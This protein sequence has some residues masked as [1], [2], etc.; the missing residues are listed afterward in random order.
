MKATSGKLPR[1]AMWMYEPKWD[2]HRVIVRTRGD[3]TDAISSNGL[4][5]LARWPWLA[6]VV[7]QA[8]PADAILDGEVIAIDENGRH[9]FGLVGRADRPHSFIVFDILAIDGRD[10][11]STPWADRRAIL[12]ERVSPVS[13]LSITPTTDDADALLAATKANGFEGVI[14]KR[15]DSLYQVGR[16]TTS[17]IKVKHR[18]EQEVVVGGYMLGEGNRSNAFGSLLVGVYEGRS[19]RF[20]GGVGTGFNERT[21]RELL[22]RLKELETATCP[23]DPDP[24]L[25]RGKFRW[26]RP[27]LVVQVEFGEWTDYGHLRHPVYLGI[28]DDKA[29]QKVVREPAP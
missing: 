18:L 3:K 28:R 14:A 24:K 1:G 5:R 23:F 16:R 22:A 27:E 29:P 6:D 7:H 12:V 21:L 13:Q 20:A 15:T 11:L 19:L 2:G 26:T 17:W 8:C 4:D 9:S 25:P 10:L